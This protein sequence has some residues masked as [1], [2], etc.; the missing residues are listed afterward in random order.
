MKKPALFCSAIFCVVLTGLVSCSKSDPPPEIDHSVIKTTDIFY[1][2]GDTMHKHTLDVYYRNNSTSRKVIFFVP[3]GAWRQGDKDQYEIMAL[4]LTSLGNY[5]VV[6]TNY[7]LSNENDGSAVHPEHVQDVALAF[8]WVM[9]NIMDYGGD[10]NSV[11]LFGQSA[12]GHLVSLLASDNQYLNQVGYSTKN[13]KGVISMSGA[14]S[15]ADLVA[16]PMNPLNLSADE[17]LMYKGIVANAFGSYDTATVNPASPS[18]HLGD[19]LPPFLLIYTELDM[20]GFAADAENCYSLMNIAGVPSAGIQKLYQSDYS[21]ETW[22]TATALAAAEPAL[23]DYIGHYAEVVAINE[24]DYLKVP[25][26]W[27]VAFIGAN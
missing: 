20:P 3:G 13:I 12:G 24:Y 14:Y 8:K 7:R 27:I 4:T 18:R 6:V 23:A 15:L 10:P 16:F 11:F 1:V 9:N 19:S 26:K 2:A 21:A 22:Q 25:T 17:V 5:T